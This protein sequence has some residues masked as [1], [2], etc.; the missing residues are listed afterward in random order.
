MRPFF[1]GRS[2]RLLFGTYHAPA[3]RSSRPGAVLLCNPF[4]QDAIYAH[5]I[6]ATLAAKL[7][8]LGQHVLRFD[9]YGTGDSAGDVEDGSQAGWIEDIIEAHQELLASSGVSRVIWVGLRYGGTLAVLAGQSLPRALA[10]LILWDPVVDGAGYLQ[11]LTEA[12]AS[13]MRQE[14]RGWRPAPT[15]DCEALGFP[16]CPDLKRAIA[17]V[18]LAG[19]RPPKARQVTVLSTSQKTCLDRFRQAVAGWSDAAHWVEVT[20]SSPWNSD[21]AMNALLVPMDLLD[22]IVARVQE[23]P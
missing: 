18:D 9:Y 2:E 15:V 6:Y 5:R 1:F 21:E 13:F 7:S 12:H 22:A 10:S 19:V 20:S 23:M 3:A 17:A 4:G 8:K 14:L 16:L 11:E